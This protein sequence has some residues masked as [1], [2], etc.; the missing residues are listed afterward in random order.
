MLRTGIDIVE[1][2]RIK[3]LV[4]HWKEKF[5]HRIYTK[6]ELQACTNR[7]PALATRFAAKEAVMKALGTGR[8]GVN[9]KEIEILTDTN[10]TPQIQLYGRAYHR[11]KEQGIDSFY[12]TLSHTK[13]YAVA[14]VI[15]IINKKEGYAR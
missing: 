3:R 8:R 13:E 12:I 14:S 10:G 15:G 7:I 5:I 4:F 11:A 2:A 6:A 9:W 1:I